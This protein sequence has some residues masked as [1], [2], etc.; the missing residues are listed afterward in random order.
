MKSIYTIGIAVLFGIVVA[1]WLSRPEGETNALPAPAVSNNLDASHPMGGNA[2]RLQ[3]QESR[4]QAIPSRES[5]AGRDV[6]SDGAMA[7]PAGKV[8]L[9]ALDT[10]QVTHATPES[11][12][13]ALNN[14]IET[15]PGQTADTKSSQPSAIDK[16]DCAAAAKT[17]EESWS[18]FDVTPTQAVAYARNPSPDP[19]APASVFTHLR[20]TLLAPL[21][22]GNSA[23]DQSYPVKMEFVAISA[24]SHV[25]IMVGD[26][27]ISDGTVLSPLSKSDQG[28]FANLFSTLQPRRGVGIGPGRNISRERFERQL[29]QNPRGLIAGP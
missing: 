2:G 9:S 19:H 20:G 15:V 14:A 25:R 16:T 7:D 10:G 24:D 23:F 5:T 26:D 27:W 1:W 11:G 28:G 12:Q 4:Q 18:I 13:V 6:G 21:C 22:S 8:T 29:A 17:L 3:Q